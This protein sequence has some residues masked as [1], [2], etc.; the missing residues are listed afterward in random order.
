[1]INQEER[2]NFPVAYLSMEIAL[3][4]GIKT[5]AGGLGVLAGDLLRAASEL[6]FPVVGVTLFNKEGYFSQKLSSSGQQEESPDYSDLSK[7]R[8]CPERARVHIGQDEVLIN[9]WEYALTSSA[10]RIVPVYLLDTDCPE[11]QDKYRR[12]SGCLYGGNREYRL[13]QEI[14]LG[15]GSVATLEALGY[16]GIKKFHLNEGH[17]A[18]AAISIFR[19]QTDFDQALVATREKVVFTTHTPV[20]EGHDVFSLGEIMEA[21]PDFPVEIPELSENGLVDFTKTALFFSSSVNAVSR[22]HAGV[23]RKL[24]PGHKI[25]SIVNGISSAYWASP[26]MSVLFDKYIPGW[27]LDNSRLEAAANIPLSEISDSQLV[28]KKRLL[29]VIKEAG[30]QGFST[31]RFTICFARRFAPYKRPEMLLADIERLLAVQ[32][33]AGPIQI[34]YA[35]KAHPHDEIGRALVADVNRAGK[36]LAGKIPFIFLP[37]YDLDLAKVLVA[38]SDLWLNNPEP[39]FE[40]SGTSGMKAALNGVP[41]ASTADGWWLESKVDDWTITEKAGSLYGLLEKEI[42]PMFYNRPEEY[43]ALRRDCIS[44]NATYFNTQRVWREYIRK[45]YGF[46]SENDYKK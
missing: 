43:A 19:R 32:K 13:W 15:R 44:L 6:D 1:M 25:I 41:Q 5:Y 45:S 9:I 36:G 14:I 33:K 24:F 31:D 3:E 21:Q 22:Q 2:K 12:L 35:G 7:I 23:S 28:A 26:E 10:G 11:N 38:G 8:L 40:A 42:L 29:D 30:G 27:R 16:S 17:G 4:E 18:L 39:P 37:D 34:V 20:A 46:K